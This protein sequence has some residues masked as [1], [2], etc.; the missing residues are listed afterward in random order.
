MVDY[1]NP[2][3]QAIDKALDAFETTDLAI[4]VNVAS[5][6]SLARSIVMNHPVMARAIEKLD[7]QFTVMVLDRLAIYSKQVADERHEHPMD[8]A[9]FACLLLLDH[10]CG[11]LGAVLRASCVVAKTIPRTWWTKHFVED[12]DNRAQGTSHS[13]P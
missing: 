1:L 12:F 13:G 2:V 10:V 9:A 11:P 3:A 6:Y 7:P 5:S 4:V 8:V